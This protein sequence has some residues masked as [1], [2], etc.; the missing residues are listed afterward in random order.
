MP[1]GDVAAENVKY[2]VINAGMIEL[3]ATESPVYLVFDTSK[4]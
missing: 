1:L 4:Q 3:T 2:R